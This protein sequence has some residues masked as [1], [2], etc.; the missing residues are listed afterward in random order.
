MDGL[1]DIEV[2]M[3]QMGVIQSHFCIYSSS[4]TVAVGA[5]DMELGALFLV[6]K[7]LSPLVS[8][9]RDDNTTQGYSVVWWECKCFGN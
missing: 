3:L 5:P 9:F 2:V 8:F 4:L 7:P 1:G 6:T